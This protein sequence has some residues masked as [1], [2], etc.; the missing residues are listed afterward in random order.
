MAS[1]TAS[2]EIDRSAEAVFRFLADGLNNP[3]WRPA[4]IDVSL[5]SGQAG[6]V[7]AIYRQLLKGPFGK[8]HGDYRVVEANPHTRIKFEVISG[9]ARPVGLFEIEPM[10]QG[11]R[12]RFSLAFE[13]KGLMRLLNGMIQRTMEGEVENL[14]GLKAA[15]ERS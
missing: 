9:P 11:A 4:V 8:I 3:K 14:S 2:V 6:S 7:G 15:L 5:V 13:P 12:V 10:G 1:A